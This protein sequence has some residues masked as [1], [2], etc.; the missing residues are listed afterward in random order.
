M[1]CV[2]C[3]PPVPAA[4]KGRGAAPGGRAKGR[5]RTAAAGRAAAPPQQGHHRFAQLPAVA[6]RRRAVPLG[7]QQQLGG[8]LRLGCAGHVRLQLGDLHSA[9]RSGCSGVGVQPEK[10]WLPRGCGA[11]SLLT[12]KASKATVLPRMLE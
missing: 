8:L 2:S 5:R 3:I 11:T 9:P 6:E 10:A 7:L 12:R 1:Q 4:P